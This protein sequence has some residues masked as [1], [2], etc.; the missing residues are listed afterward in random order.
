MGSFGVICERVA[1]HEQTH[2]D[3]KKHPCSKCGELVWFD[4]DYYPKATP[5]CEECTFTD[6]GIKL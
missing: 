1:T 3:C 5:K 4:E 6:W 2:P